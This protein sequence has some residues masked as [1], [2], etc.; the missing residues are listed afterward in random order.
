MSLS[1]SFAGN[2][3]KILELLAFHGPVAAAINAIPL[4]FY[5]GGVVQHN[6]EPLLNHAVQI[7]GYDVTGDLRYYIVRNA[8]GADFGDQGYAKIEIGRNVCG[9]ASQISTVFL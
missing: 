8:W 3:Q 1:F 4:R 5:M 9:I 6:C 7:V 2:E